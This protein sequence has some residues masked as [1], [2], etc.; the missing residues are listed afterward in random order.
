MPWFAVQIVCIQIHVANTMFTEMAPLVGIM[1][2]LRETANLPTILIFGNLDSVNM[3]VISANFTP[4]AELTC[5][6]KDMI[7][8]SICNISANC[9]LPLFVEAIN[10]LRLNHLNHTGNLSQSLNELTRNDI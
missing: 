6:Y 10:H 2:F 5:I 7:L 9:R 4:L 3:Y 1:L 8:V